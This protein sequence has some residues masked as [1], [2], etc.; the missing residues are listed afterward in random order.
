MFPKV[1][2]PWQFSSSSS[3]TSSASS[4]S[5][6]QEWIF[7]DHEPLSQDTQSHMH[8]R[9]V[10]KSVNNAIGLIAPDFT[11]VECCDEGLGDSPLDS[12]IQDAPCP[13]LVHP[14][15][16]DFFGASCGPES[17]LSQCTPSASHCDLIDSLPQFG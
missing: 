16:D 8:V 17:D 1:R 5:D 3:C 7:F 14:D 2:G 10:K 6:T 11:M 15:D 4:L 9:G 12:H 13:S